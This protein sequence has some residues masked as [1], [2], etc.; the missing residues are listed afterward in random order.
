MGSYFGIRAI[1]K[2]TK[3]IFAKELKLKLSLGT[4]ISKVVYS[5]TTKTGETGSGTVTSTTTVPAIFG[6]TFNFTPTA[7]SG[8]TISSYTSSHYIYGDT[9]ISF[10]AKVSGSGGGCVTGETPLLVS[11]D[12]ATKEAKNIVKGSK[13]VAFDSAKNK[14]VETVISQRFV[15]ELPIRVFVLHLNDD[16]ELHITGKHRIL[17]V[18]GLKSVLDEN[19][20]IQIDCETKVVGKDGVKTVV[21]ISSYVTEENTVVYNYQTEKGDSFV[22]SGVVVENEPDTTT[23][24]LV[25]AVSANGIALQSLSGSDISK[26]HV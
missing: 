5:Y 22:A 19:D 10:S 17:T 20:N 16:S 26:G 18:D 11:L 1:Y 9:T 3:L 25:N 24:T 23:G 2:D 4:G 13:I 6:S 21:G 12:G 14:F 15:Q 8:Y 7:A